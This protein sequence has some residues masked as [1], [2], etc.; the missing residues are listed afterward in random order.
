MALGACALLRQD[1]IGNSP[2]N[3]IQMRLHQTLAFC[4]AAVVHT[5]TSAADPKSAESEQVRIIQAMGEQL[6]AR[7]DKLPVLIAAEHP[8]GQISEQ[9]FTLNQNAVVVEGQRFDGLVITAPGAPATFA[10]AFVSPPNA[11]SWYILREKGEM[12]GF[13]NFLR[14]PRSSLPLSASMQPQSGSD[15]TFQKL[16]A[17]AWT[18]TERTIVWF[19]FID[20]SPAAITLR[21]GFF[22]RPSL[23]NNAL[24]ALLF[25]PAPPAQPGGSL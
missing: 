7:I 10:W 21:A 13:A 19:R 14:R 1:P 11:A 24:P 8:V 5:Q 22:A 9:M 20:D 15:V 23:N 16:D 6:R 4:I 3:I 12:K 17:S 25:P 18:P 2:V